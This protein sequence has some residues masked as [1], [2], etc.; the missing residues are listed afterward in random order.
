MQKSAR[1]LYF[2][3]AGFH[4]GVDACIGNFHV[5]ASVVMVVL[6]SGLINMKYASDDQ[7]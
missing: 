3:S 2:G 6:T 4:A 7:I 5:S 1:P